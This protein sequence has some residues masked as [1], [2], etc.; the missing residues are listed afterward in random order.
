[1][2]GNPL[3]RKALCEYV[4]AEE[5][6]DAM[7]AQ[8]PEE[9]KKKLCT[10]F[11]MHTSCRAIETFRQKRFNRAGGRAAFVAALEQATAA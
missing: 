8:T 9:I 5:A 10:S 11:G 6:I 7:A 3:K 2:G 4:G 1:M